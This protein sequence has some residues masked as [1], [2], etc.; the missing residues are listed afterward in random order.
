MSSLGDLAQSLAGFSA[1]S[2]A[3]ETEKIAKLLEEQ[4]YLL[5][6]LLNQ[7][8]S[9]SPRAEPKPSL[10]SQDLI[11]SVEHLLTQFDFSK[12]HILPSLAC[13]LEPINRAVI[14]ELAKQTQEILESSEWKYD[15]SDNQKFLLLYVLGEVPSEPM[16]KIFYLLFFAREIAYGPREHYEYSEIWDN[17]IGPGAKE[18]SAPTSPEREALDMHV[19][20]DLHGNSFSQRLK[21]MEAWYFFNLFGSLHYAASIN[22]SQRL[23]AIRAKSKSITAEELHGILKGD[24]VDELLDYA[25]RVRTGFSLPE[26]LSFQALKTHDCASKPPLPFLPPPP[27][28]PPFYF[29]K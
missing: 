27:P 14:S 24:T 20:F 6:Q 7:K 5:S 28:P 22:S 18:V 3:L 23:S 11:E 19:A 16:Q 21:G 25:I 4:N 1:A 9:D 2:T 29:N 10:A 13:P 15:L 8:E 17:V 12:N 26:L